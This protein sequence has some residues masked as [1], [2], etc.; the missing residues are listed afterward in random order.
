VKQTVT[1]PLNERGQGRNETSERLQPLRSIQKHLTH[2]D[3]QERS[4]EI[5][6]RS[7]T[8]Y[9]PEGDLIFMPHFKYCSVFY[10]ECECLNVQIKVLNKVDIH[11]NY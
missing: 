10:I 3:S 6:L 8:A 9:Q 5:R 4:K 1:A 2:C 11:I 7:D